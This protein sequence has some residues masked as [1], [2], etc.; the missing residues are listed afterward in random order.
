MTRNETPVPAGDTLLIRTASIHAGF[1]P[2][3]GLPQRTVDRRSA[4]SSV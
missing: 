1:C 2:A 4:S 3:R